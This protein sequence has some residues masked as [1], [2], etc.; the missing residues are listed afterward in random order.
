MNPDKLRII[1]EDI[2]NEISEHVK[3]IKPGF[4]Y[5]NRWFSCPV[6]EIYIRRSFHSLPSRDGKL[7]VTNTLDLANVTVND[8]YRGKGYFT[9]LLRNIEKM[10]AYH[11]LT[12]YVENILEPRL[13][14]FLEREDYNKIS[15]DYWDTPTM[16]KHHTDLLNG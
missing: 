2:N 11:Q 3:N 15:Y 14:S 5:W 10:A 7:V 6:L 8:E 9:H 13:A 1:I 4:G 12:L 16:W